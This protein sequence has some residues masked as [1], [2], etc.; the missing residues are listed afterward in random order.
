MTVVIV[1]I[2]ASDPLVR[3]SVRSVL[4]VCCFQISSFLVD[5]LAVVSLVLRH[6]LKTSLSLDQR[7][8]QA[9][10]Q[11]KRCARR[12]GLENGR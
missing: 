9:D 5:R 1:V 12:R 7:R 11:P 4:S 2:L 3:L 6:S 10:D 8:T